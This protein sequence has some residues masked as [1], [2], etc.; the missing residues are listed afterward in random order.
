MIFIFFVSPPSLRTIAPVMREHGIDYERGKF[1]AKLESGA[2]TLESTKVIF[3]F[4][5][6]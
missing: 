3:L 4:C 6:V 1:A 5:F 2:L